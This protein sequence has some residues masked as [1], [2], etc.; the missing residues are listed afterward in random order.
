MEKQGIISRLDHNAAPE[1]LNSFVVVK[2]PDS[3]LRIC[4][5]PTDLNKYI[6]RPV[7]HSNTLDEVSFKLKDA[8]FFSVIDAIK[9]FFHLPLNKN[10]WSFD[11]YAHPYRSVC[12]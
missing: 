9:E 6:V 3:D 7:C 11:S 2:K 5:G 4:L 12:I 8:E 10:I 1:W